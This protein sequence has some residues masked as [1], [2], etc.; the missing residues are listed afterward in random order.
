MYTIEITE[1]PIGVWTQVYKEGVLETML[2]GGESKTDAGPNAGPFQPL[3]TDYKEY[4]TDCTVRFVV[5]MTNKQF[6]HAMDQGGLHKFFKLQKTISLNNMVLFDSKGCL[7]RYES[8]VDILNEFY[9]MRLSL[10]G[11]RKEYLENMLGAECAKLDNIA[12]FIVEKCDGK[13]KVE[14]LRKNDLIK[15][16][17][18]RGYQSDPIKKWKE[19]I[20]KER[21]YLHDSVGG[22][23]NRN[24]IADEQD[25]VENKNQDYNYLLSMPLWNLTMEKKEEILKQQ[26]Q[27]GAELKALQAKTREQLW[28]DDLAEFKLELEKFEQREREEMEISIKKNVSKT[29]KAAASSSSSNLKSIKYE[30]LPTS[31]AERIEPKMDA[32]LL[33]RSEQQRLAQKVKKEENALN[34]VEIISSE[35]GELGDEQ[36][37]QMNEIVAN[38]ANPNRVKPTG[39]GG[40]KATNGTPKKQ[41]AV[42]K[43]KT[44]NNGDANGHEENGAEE[45]G[46]GD[47]SIDAMVCIFEK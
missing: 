11:K 40:S 38:L 21:G 16:L 24:A 17:A 2:N 45:N 35:M 23:A 47:V 41:P 33:Q 28:L 4:H 12:R 26:R 22:E 34:I 25:E 15:L 6:Q 13:I 7:R 37:K 19:K 9:G 8:P 10:Y 31:D 3:I 46:G 1:L 30:Y 20:T 5:K 39:G 43:E 29:A 36:R 44:E 18:D 27:K 32:Q 14:N 42:K